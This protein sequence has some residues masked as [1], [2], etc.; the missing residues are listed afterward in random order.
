[1]WRPELSDP[2]VPRYLAIA[3]ALAR[4]LAQG[5]LHPGARLPTHRDLA[6]ALGVTVG[7]V[8]RA[9]AEAA[10][11]GLVSGEV[12]RGTF[13]RAPQA[14]DSLVAAPEGTLVDLSVN[15]PPP[16]DSEIQ[17][18]LADTLRAVAA[19][20]QLQTLLSYPPEGGLPAHRAAGAEWITRAGV[21]A[22]PADVLVTNG[23]QHAMTAVLA[24]LLQPG[25]VLL[26]ESLTYAGLKA[27]AG[28]L[29]FRLHG[30]AL[31]EHGLR[32]EAFEAACRGGGVK[33]LYCVPTLH[34]PTTSIM[35]LARR[36]EI[37]AIA[38]HH[39][40]T[41]IEDD[42]HGL[43]ASEAPAPLAALAP[44]QTLY[45]TGTAKC[46]APGLRI[47]F[48]RAPSARVARIAA[49][50]RTTTWM[51]APLMAE[52]VATW[53]RAG[54]AE[55]VVAARR[56]EAAARQALAQRLLGR[57]SVQSQSHAH[58][59]WL[60]LPE[61]WRSDTFADEARRRGVRVTPASAFLVGRGSA[62]HAVRVCL[63]A[64]RDHAQLEQGLSLLVDVL[65]GPAD[66]GAV[67]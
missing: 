45:L 64:A 33:A 11:R 27:L 25:D 47:G 21:P 63:G 31:D 26:T 39:G 12:G 67:L 38:R 34:N 50:I 60:H 54:T 29:H 46:L 35:P 4:D 28:L 1:M 17:R 16:A 40:V 20:T 3:E 37:V 15:H 65:D 59:L 58:H 36:H 53:V 62:P 2:H 61:P 18:A 41:L 43:L 10:R 48:V 8:T 44:E 42:V 66:A 57:F 56:A 30:L 19:A 5:R 24:T 52:V 6:D 32:P 7:T 22:E 51:A 23:I 55:R 14:L 49:S 13:T 9:Y